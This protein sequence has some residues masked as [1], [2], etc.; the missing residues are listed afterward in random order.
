M[1]K[2][3]TPTNGLIQMVRDGLPEMTWMTF[4][5]VLAFSCIATRIISGLQG[6]QQTRDPSEPRASRLAPYWFP[7]LGHSLSFTWN[8]ASLFQGLRD[9]MDESV[10]GVYLRGETHDTVISPSMIKTIL[11]SSKNSS[12][13][14]DQALHNV[15]G[16]RN[17]IH[18][19]QQSR[20]QEISDDVPGFISKESF[21]S[22]ASAAITKMVQRNIPNLVSFSQSP[23][24]Q[25][26][27]E[28]DS[29][30]V[31]VVQEGESVCEADLFALVRNFV[32]HHMSNFLM[33]EAFL[34]NFPMVV[35]DLWKLDTNFVSLFVG[36]PR[37]VPAPGVSAGHAACDRLHHIMSIFYRAFTAWDDGID[38]GIELRELDDVSELVKERM[39]TFRKL[40]MTPGASAAGNLSLY[41]D[42]MEHIT[43]ITFWTTLH[44]FADSALLKEI[45]KEF[46]PYVNSSRPSREE[47]GFPFDEP[48]RLSLDLDNVLESCTLLK[49]CYHETVRLHSAGV[50]FRRLESDLTLTESDEDATEPCTY[51]LRKGEKVIMPHVAYQTDARRFSNPDQYD[52]LRFVVTDPASGRKQAS[53]DALGPFAEG[54]YG[55]KDNQLN[56]RSIL[57]FTAGIVSMWDITSADE[58]VLK[59]PN[60][61][62]TWGSFQ[63]SKDIRVRMKSTV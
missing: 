17:L 31:S 51:K 50:S 24:D 32:G 27:W 11:S 12:L 55:I 49:A 21:L 53:A 60:N 61:K 33:G 9:S 23:V 26:P 48:P 14:L 10:F 34:E 7:W 57:A 45:R 35:E 16:N 19:L 28:R 1:E 8:H 52:P 44:I 58:K 2:Y 15:F 41:W 47:T 38:P 4:F 3:E 6:R 43:K 5:A 59:I 39:R 18:S 37:Y 56:E 46:A 22:E 30:K 40:E 29:S 36:L 25:A 13:A 63:P 20:N 42:V 54:L 62:S